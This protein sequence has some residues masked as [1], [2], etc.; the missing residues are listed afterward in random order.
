LTTES[1]PLPPNYRWN[2]GAFVAD[3]ASFLIAFS[4]ISAASVLPAFVRQLTTSTLLIGFSSTVF[5]AGWTLPQLATARLLRDKPRKKPFLILGMPIRA[6]IPVIAIALWAGL[7]SRPSAMLVLFFSC[8]ALFA[9]SDGFIS[10]PWFEILAR[11]IPNRR[12]GRLMGV[13]QFIGGAAGIGV[14][15]LVGLIL[16]RWSFP[17][18]YALLFTCASA[19]MAVSTVA[20]VLL[21]EPP[22]EEKPDDAEQR[23]GNWLRILGTD[24]DFRR[25]MVCRILVGM[26]SLATPFYV[27]HAADAM[28]L[29][30]SI[31]GSFVIAGTAGSLASSVLLGLASE[32]IGTR[33]IIRFTSAISIAGPLF[34]LAVDVLRI[35]WLTQ[36]YPI[37]FVALGVTTSSWMLGF[38]NYMLEMSPDAIRPAYMGLGNTLMGVM[39]LVPT[40][41]GWLLQAT[42]YRVLFGLAALLTGAG[43]M[44]TFTLRSAETISGERDA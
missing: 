17:Q 19:G 1:E 4:F 12:R 22:A 10:V 5:N 16:D 25:L 9:L 28:G 39:A 21:R 23:S 30:E 2:F 42:S 38:T 6:T 3:Y 27:T 20:L 18:N 34:V 40:V 8:M 32:R 13:S 26:I 35:G 37:A 14:G 41:G 36:A 43:A 7:A 44:L 15:A 29:P 31:I 11:T 33:F 24:A